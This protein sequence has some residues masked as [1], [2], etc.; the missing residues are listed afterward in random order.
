MAVRDLSH[1]VE[2]L[3]ASLAEIRRTLAGLP[4]QIEDVA[5]ASRRRLGRA[6]DEVTE[7]ARE[8]VDALEGEIGA[9]PLVAVGL[10]FLIGMAFDRFLLR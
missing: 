5:S 3:A 10:A 9:H 7:R 4:E 6:T 2:S 1:E 8:G